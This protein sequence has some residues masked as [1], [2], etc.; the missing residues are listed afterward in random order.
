[1]LLLTVVAAMGAMARAYLASSARV[2]PRRL[3]ATG[4]LLDRA[5][6]R[7]ADQGPA[8]PDVR[9]PHRRSARGGRPFAA[10]GCGAAA[11]PG[12][13]WLCVL[14]LPWFLAIFSRRASNFFAEL[15]GHDLIE[16]A[17][18]RP[19]G[20]WRTAGHYF[21]LFWVTFWPGATLAGMAAPGVWAARRE[22]GAHFLLAWIVPAWI[23]LELV[24][25]KL[26]HYVLPLYPAIAILIAGVIDPH[27]LA[28]QRWLTRGTGWWFV[29]PLI[30]G[31]GAI[32]MLVISDASSACW[33]GRSLRQR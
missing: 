8:D 28:R 3:D 20:A 6:G 30:V 27:V 32:V 9:R 1:M 24:I 2:R 12:V 29:L 25:T 17:V 19:G 23:V 16:Q 10:L 14:V 31:I 7:R 18:Q 5:C 13:L 15:V 33:L 11:L 4:D 26:P 22:K 21:V